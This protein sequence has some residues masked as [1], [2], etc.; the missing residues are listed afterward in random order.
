MDTKIKT[1]TRPLY[2][3]IAATIRDDIR[4]GAYAPGVK[5]PSMAALATT[6]GVSDLTI[7]RALKTLQAEGYVSIRHGLGT[8]VLDRPSSDLELLHDQAQQLAD[9]AAALVASID[10][11]RSAVP[12]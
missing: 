2:E 5:L 10:K 11:L 3:Q 9:L 6:H 8:F 4:Q 12:A 1:D 7:D